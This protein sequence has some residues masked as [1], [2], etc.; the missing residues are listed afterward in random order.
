MTD[1]AK[2]ELVELVKDQLSQMI[3]TGDL[4]IDPCENA[5]VLSD[6]T[7]KNRFTQLELPREQKKYI[8]TVIQNMPATL[9]AGTLAQAYRVE[10]PKGLP[11]TLATL[12][13]GG[14]G[15][16]IVDNGKFV[17]SASFYAMTTQ[18]MLTGAFSVMS[19]VCG[20]FYLGQIN[21]ELQKIN[22]KL[23]DILEFLY[24]DKY[25]ELMSE[26][27][28]VQDV[29][30]N[31]A[32][33]M[34]HEQQRI[35]TIASLQD[36]KKVAMKNIEFYANDLES[37]AKF[38]VAATNFAE[39]EPKVRKFLQINGGLEL[40]R[41]L[42]VMSSILEVY[43]AQNQD[44]EYLAKA[45]KDIRTYIAKCNKQAQF[46]S[47]ATY[48]DMSK[49]KFNKKDKDQLESSHLEKAV[50][51]LSKAADNVKD[52]PMIDVV[53][54]AIDSSAKKNEYYLSKD[55]NIYMM[56]GQS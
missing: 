9:A 13:Q 29:H 38:D 27:S 20:M 39:L 32:S 31:Y 15:S 14:V 22:M 16:M 37:K 24:G 43:F 28:F 49:A 3:E 33:I 10:F 19:A 51:D 1:Q 7:D 23:D 36:A 11:H 46:G 45:K 53:Y 47:V 21:R 17:G 42:Y 30:D 18:A 55:G 52:Q 50:A 2:N 6:L 35:A 4:K 41:Q 12:K 5:F 40:S 8:S 34:V 26:M 54:S 48:I 56:N 25:A 44:S